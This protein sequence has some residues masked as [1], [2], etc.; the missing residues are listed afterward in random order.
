[1]TLEVLAGFKFGCLL[2]HIGSSVSGT[3]SSAAMSTSCTTSSATGVFSLSHLE[4][5]FLGIS[6]LVI[7]N[8]L[9]I[10][11]LHRQYLYKLSLQD[12][13][14]ELDPV[15]FVL[16]LMIVLIERPPPISIIS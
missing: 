12:V 14:E 2:R 10:T 5:E 11:A 3:T 1:V 16:V 13:L 4:V 6:F 15:Q 7:H 9:L 8:P